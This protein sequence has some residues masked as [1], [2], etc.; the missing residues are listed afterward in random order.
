MTFLDV[1]DRSLIAGD[2]FTTHLKLMAAGVFYFAFPFPALFRQTQRS[3]QPALQSS[4]RSIPAGCAWGTG[5]RLFL[6]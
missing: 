6:L 4:G 5:I 2:A 1:R 3:L